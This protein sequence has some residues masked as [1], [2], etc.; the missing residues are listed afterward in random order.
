MEVHFASRNLQCITNAEWSVVVPSIELDDFVVPSCHSH[1]HSH[2]R[3]QS[4]TVSAAVTFE[5]KRSIVAIQCNWRIGRHNG[6][7]TRQLHQ[8][9][10]CSEPLIS[11]NCQRT[12]ATE[13]NPEQKIPRAVC[14]DG[15]DI[16]LSC[17][18]E[19]RHNV[20]ARFSR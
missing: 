17:D 19:H 6:L 10:C 12:H 8:F 9:R 5:D 15:D 14:D 7:L 2:S 1:S 3:P 4:L 18:G 13:W 20:Y 11:Y 16:K